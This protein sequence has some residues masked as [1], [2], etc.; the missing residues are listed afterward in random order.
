MG[1][2]RPAKALIC[3]SCRVPADEA[4]GDGEAR[5]L[6]VDEKTAAGALVVLIGPS[7]SGKS[8]F[9]RRHFK[10]TEV[11][12]SDACRALV[13]DDE[14]D[15]SATP[16][17]FAVLHCIVEQRLR[18]GRRTVVDATNVQAKARKPLLDLARRYH[19]PAIAIVFDLP[20]ETCKGHNRSRTDRVVADFVVDRQRAQAPLDASVLEAEG[21]DRVITFHSQQEVEAYG[22]A[23]VPSPLM[24]RDRPGPFDIIGDVHGCDRELLALL[25]ALGYRVEDP[26][27]LIPRI[28]APPGRTAVFVG[29]LVDRGPDSVRT[30]LIAMAMVHTGTA[31]A[32]PGNHDDKLLRALRGVSVKMNNGLDRT[33]QELQAAG[34]DVQALVRE[35]LASLPAHLVL[36]RGNLVVAH[37]GLPEE[38][39]GVD[40]PGARDT[41][42]FGTPTGERDAY[43]IKVLVDWAHAYKGTALVVW[44]HLPV[45][46][47]AW[48]GNTIDI[49]TGCVH[50]GRLTAL[51]YPERELVSVPAERVYSTPIKP[52]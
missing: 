47:A 42:L 29:D 32:V 50:G 40:S 34:G 7:G 11:V 2:L 14:A 36:D 24:A 37:A 12:S 6:T 28:T 23:T 8:T 5:R 9:A 22:K 43:G 41:A 45:A 35:F 26:D 27:A 16:A 18:A 52:L 31:L 44:G 39:Q 30:L 4:R 51:R 46:H 15:Q 38:L 21:F 20:V 10:P 17:A 33:I 25:A 49:D 1:I 48:V 13:A 19:R 3:W